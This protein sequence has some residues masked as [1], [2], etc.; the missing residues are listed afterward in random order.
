MEQIELKTIPEIKQAVDE[1][2]TVHAGS[3]GYIVKKKSGS[4]EYIIV[5]KFN[6]HIIGLHGAVG[7]KYENDLNGSDFYFYK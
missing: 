4:N 2:K 7:S 5:C 1:G 6:N 3:D